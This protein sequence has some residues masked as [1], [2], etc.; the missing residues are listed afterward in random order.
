MVN[1]GDDN[2]RGKPAP[3]CFTA[4]A[5][6]FGV[7]ASACLVF[8]DA[9]AGVEA[10]TAAGMRVIAIPSINDKDAYPKP[11]LHRT[12]GESACSSA[13]TFFRCCM[14]HSSCKKGSPANG[15][16]YILADAHSTNAVLVPVVHHSKQ[17]IAD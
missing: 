17:G 3:D 6:E 13:L 15:N 10:A 8:E 1:C 12:Q 16:W 5:K 7:A 9:P 4:T 14:L 11:D 2:E